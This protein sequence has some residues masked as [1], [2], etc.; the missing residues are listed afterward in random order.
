[1]I[2]EASLSNQNIQIDNDESS[3]KEENVNLRGIRFYSEKMYYKD[4]T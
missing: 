3:K 1:M 2:I 4:L